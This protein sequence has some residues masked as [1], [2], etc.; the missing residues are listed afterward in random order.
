MSG[1]PDGF[2]SDAGCKATIDAPFIHAT[3][4]FPLRYLRNVCVCSDGSVVHLSRSLGLETRSL[5]KI[6]TPEELEAKAEQA[7]PEEAE[8]SASRCVFEGALASHSG[9]QWRLAFLGSSC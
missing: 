1:E 2:S 3:S 7:S 6:P 4:S 5:E 8:E 9:G